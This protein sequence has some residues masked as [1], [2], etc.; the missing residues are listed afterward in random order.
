MQFRATSL[1]VRSLRQPSYQAARTFIAPSAVVSKDAVQDVFIRELRN[2]KP[3][4]TAKGSELD[5]VKTFQ[6]PAAPKAPVVEDDITAAIAEY[7][8][9]DVPATT[10][11]A[12]S[13]SDALP[14]EY[15]IPKEAEPVEEAH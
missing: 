1:I 11:S 5:Q 7:A 6:A 13:N 14:V 8:R 15:L 3:T 4:A 10:Q 2:Y 12:G 9:D